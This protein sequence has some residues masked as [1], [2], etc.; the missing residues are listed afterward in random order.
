MIAGGCAHTAAGLACG[1]V[2]GRVGMGTR[3]L[4]EIDSGRDFP[5]V[6]QLGDARHIRVRGLEYSGSTLRD[7]TYAYGLVEIAAKK[8]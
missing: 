1:A 2:I 7:V 4:A 5:D 3:V 6:A 8:R